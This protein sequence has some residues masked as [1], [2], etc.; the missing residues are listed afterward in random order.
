[1]EAPPERCPLAFGKAATDV[2][3]APSSRGAR[4]PYRGL[5]FRPA[6]E[7]PAGDGWS[8]VGGVSGP[9]SSG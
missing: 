4:G 7:Q 9:Q 1:M 2:V 5:A 3:L 6:E 8:A